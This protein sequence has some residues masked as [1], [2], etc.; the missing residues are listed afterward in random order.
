MF[1][2]IKNWN[3]SKNEEGLIRMLNYLKWEYKFGSI[4]DINDDKW[5]IIYSP[6]EPLDF[7]KNPNKLWLFGP[8]FCMYDGEKKFEKI[9]VK[10]DNII[11]TQPSKWPADVYKFMHPELII[12][13]K[14]LSFPVNTDRFNEVN[15]INQRTEVLIYYKNRKM[16]ELSFI[17]DNLNQRNI[18]NFRIFSYTHKYDENDFINYLK[19]C[20]YAIIVDRH[21]S[22]GFAIEEMLSCNIPLLVWNVKSLNQEEGFIHP[23]YPATSIPYWDERCGEFFYNA[24][25]FNDKYKLFIDNLD[26]YKPREFI[27]D[28]LSTEKCAERL[29][30]ITNINT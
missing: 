23:D 8:H 19:V 22:Q 18:N 20:K 9:N 29:K 15:N 10:Q 16:S 27:M 24:D 30:L 2:I 11:L 7:T 26:K 28:T 25:E 5:K 14:T 1:L 21:E 13:M 4:D 12:N 3:H 17:V 6:S